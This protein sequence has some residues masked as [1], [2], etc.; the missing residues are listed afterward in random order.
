MDVADQLQLDE[1]VFDTLAAEMDYFD[2]NDINELAQ[3]FD[4]IPE[5]EKRALFGE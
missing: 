4:T 3:E 5:D 1:T 2:D